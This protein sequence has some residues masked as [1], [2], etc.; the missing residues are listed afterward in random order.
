[1]LEPLSPQ[2]STG[3]EQVLEPRTSKETMK[4]FRTILVILIAIAV[5][6]MGIY[7]GYLVTKGMFGL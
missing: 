7:G 4:R 2:L 6:T 5:V 3:C 1:M